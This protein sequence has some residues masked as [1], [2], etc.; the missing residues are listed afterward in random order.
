MLM[1]LAIKQVNTQ[2]RLRVIGFIINE[3]KKL[4]A[5]IAEFK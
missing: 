1:V 5:I 3:K 2:D 4:E